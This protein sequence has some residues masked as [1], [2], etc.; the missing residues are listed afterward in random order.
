MGHLLLAT[1]TLPSG[2]GQK[3]SMVCMNR[4]GQH[5][6]R[7]PASKACHELVSCKCKKGYVKHCKCKKAALECI[8][9]CAC[10]GDCLEN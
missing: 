9:L 7:L 5:Y 8:A 3:Q 6:L 10:E 2:A 1:Q 4:T